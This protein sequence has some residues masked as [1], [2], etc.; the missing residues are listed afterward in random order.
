MISGRS[1]LF[2]SGSQRGDGFSALH[3]KSVTLMSYVYVVD[4]NVADCKSSNHGGHLSLRRDPIVRTLNG[5][6][7]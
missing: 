2:P 7:S 1:S 4:S 5:M 3:A 6:I